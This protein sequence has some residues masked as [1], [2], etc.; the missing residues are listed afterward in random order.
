MRILVIQTAFIGDIVL[1]T[2][3]LRALAL[4]WPHA[5]IHLVTTGAGCEVLAGWN[6]V[7][8]HPMN[9]A[10]GFSASIAK[11]LGSLLP[12]GE[13]DVVFAVHRSIRSLWLGRKLKAKKRVAFRSIASALLGYEQVPYPEYR[14]DAHYAD[15]PMAL[16]S[17]FGEVPAT[18][19]PF[20]CIAAADEVWFHQEVLGKVHSKYIVLSPFSVWGTKIW[21]SD[22]YARLAQSLAKEHGATIVLIGSQGTQ[23]AIV[24]DAISEKVSRSGGRVLNLVGKTTLGQLK[25]V[26]RGAALLIS[27]DSAPVHVASAF[28]VPTVAIFGPTVRKWGFFPLATKSVVVERHNLSCRPCHIHGPTRCPKRHFRCMDEI[29]VEDVMKAAESFL[30]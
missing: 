20:L 27:N 13:F 30:V 9:K 14:E 18:P 24:A 12:H 17:R 29:Q 1:T 4:K 23:E 21:F 7:R 11:V 8:L 6:Q 3:F 19:R 10:L 5:E 15:K 26:I 25:A 16:L 28:D 22:R 2:S